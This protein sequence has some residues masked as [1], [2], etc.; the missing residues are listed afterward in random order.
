MKS[1]QEEQLKKSKRM[2][3]GLRITTQYEDI[4]TYDIDTIIVD[5]YN[6]REIKDEIEK[7]LTKT[8]FKM[9]GKLHKW[10]KI[11]EHAKT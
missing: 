11:Y 6:R 7:L 9:Y 1:N 3:V 4:N 2:M 10:K 8:G 5:G